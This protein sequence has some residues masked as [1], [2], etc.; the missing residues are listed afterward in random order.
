LGSQN[1]GYG[2]YTWHTN[3]DSYDKIMFN[4]LKRNVILTALLTYQAAQDDNEISNEKRILPLDSNGK[5]QEWPK[6]KSPNRSG[7]YK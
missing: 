2:G 4:E 3:R 6:P 5:I 7:A 1:W